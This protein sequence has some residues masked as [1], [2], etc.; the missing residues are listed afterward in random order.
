MALIMLLMINKLE[1]YRDDNFIV[2]AS[3]LSVA[4]DLSV[5]HK[6]SP[7]YRFICT[8]NNIEE[9]DLFP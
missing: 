2:G 9:I 7:H 3:R 8:V 5:Q 6:G 1:V 4:V